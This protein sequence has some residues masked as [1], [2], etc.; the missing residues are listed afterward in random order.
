MWHALLSVGSKEIDQ[1]TSTNKTRETLYLLYGD[2]F[3][4]KKEEHFYLNFIIEL[5]II[6]SIT[7]VV[8]SYDIFYF[9]LLEQCLALFNVVK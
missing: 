8:I 4:F 6:Y 3:F 5:T 1:F 2:Y 7:F 9:V